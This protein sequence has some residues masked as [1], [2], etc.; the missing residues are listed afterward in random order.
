MHFQATR[1]KSLKKTF[2]TSEV[3][4]NVFLCICA[5]FQTNRIKSLK[6]FSPLGWLRTCFDAVP[7]RQ[8]QVFKKLFFNVWSGSKRVFMHLRILPDHQNQVIKKL[9]FSPLEWLKR[10]LMHFLTTR[11]KSFKNYFSMSGVLKNVFWWN[12]SPHHQIQ[13]TKKLFFNV[14]IVVKNV[15]F[16]ISRPPE[17][18][19][20]KRLFLTSEVSEKVFLC[21]CAYFQTTRIKSLKNYFFHLW[22]GWKRVLM[23]FQ[24]T[25]INSLQ[26]TFFNV[27][28][29]RKRVFMHLCVLPDH[30]N[31]FLKKWFKRFLMHFQTTRFKSLKND[32]LTSGVV[33]NVFWC[34]SRTPESSP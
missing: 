1:I 20:Y 17:S 19:P 16:S 24:A 8:N 23:H 14:W 6:S 18:S 7:D 12:E 15:F 2:L 27:W 30:Q 25:R 13:V 26:K 34:I 4:G 21:I 3:V 31:Q 5:Y 9:F 32:F 10:V 33:K 11:I 22:S 29:G 28:S